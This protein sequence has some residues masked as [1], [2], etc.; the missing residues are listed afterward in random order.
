VSFGYSAGVLL[1]KV[2]LREDG[3]RLKPND[4]QLIAEQSALHFSKDRPRKMLAD[5]TGNGTKVYT[6]TGTITGWVNRFSYFKKIEYPINSDP[7]IYLQSD[8]YSIYE[9]ATDTE[10][11]VLKND[12]PSASQILRVTFTSNHTFT[13]VTQT[14]D[15]QDKIAFCLLMAF[16]GAMA[17]VSDF[18]KSNRSSLPNDSVDYSQKSRDM[19]A[20]ADSL[21]KKYSEIVTGKSEAV[22]SYGTY[23]KDFDMTGRYGNRYFTVPDGDR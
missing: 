6:L 17:L 21:F 23:I 3:N 4:W 18:L 2:S 16:Y 9:S 1:A 11:L 15:D 7:K 19:Q 5:I 20:L 12:S 10:Q 8:N 13:D 22:K 14:I